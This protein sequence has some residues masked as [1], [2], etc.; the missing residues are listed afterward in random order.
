MKYFIAYWLPPLIWMGFMF[1]T[2]DALTADSTSFIIIP[3]IKLLMPN[4]SQYTLDTL[5]ELVRKASHFISYGFLTLLLFRAFRGKT[6]IFYW[7]WIFYAG[8]IS[9]SYGFLDEFSQAF[10]PSRTG[11][12]YDWL[13]DS[14]GIIFTSVIIYIKG[15]KLSKA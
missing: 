4:A 10:I 3:L 12:L 5:H 6:K 9:I 14:S 2:N 11:S 7:K 8:L 1:P 13:I 15:F